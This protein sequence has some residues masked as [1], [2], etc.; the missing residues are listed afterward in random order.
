VWT[1][2]WRPEPGAVLPPD[3]GESYCCA[4]VARKPLRTGLPDAASSA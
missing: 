2:Q 4:V 1:P 3:A